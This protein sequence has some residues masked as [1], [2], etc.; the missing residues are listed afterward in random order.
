MS[1]P[2]E[3]RGSNRSVTDLHPD[4]IASVISTQIGTFRV[5][6]RGHRVLTCNRV[7]SGYIIRSVVPIYQYFADRFDEIRN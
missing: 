4:V 1:T 5:D 2:A 7:T 6:A 3:Q